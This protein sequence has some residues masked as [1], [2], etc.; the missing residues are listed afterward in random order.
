MKEYSLFSDNNK[1]IEDT[2]FIVSQI[3]YFK[4]HNYSNGI[5]A[6][7]LKL[8]IFDYFENEKYGTFQIG[9]FGSFNIDVNFFENKRI[10]I[11]LNK[12]NKENIAIRI[13][14]SLKIETFDIEKIVANF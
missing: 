2:K 3:L 12:N 7:K 14:D 11:L 9:T 4:E 13:E 6:K 8:E 1:L 5:I 10:E